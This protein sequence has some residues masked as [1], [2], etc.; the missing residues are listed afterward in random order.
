MQNPLSTVQLI[1]DKLI[2]DT[3]FQYRLEIAPVNHAFANETIGGMQF[4][5][6][7]R[8]F[9]LGRPALAYALTQLV[10]PCAAKMTVQVEHNDGCKIWLN[11]RPVYEQKGDRKI[12]LVLNE[13]SL[14]MS[15]ECELNLC[16]GRIP[17]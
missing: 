9:G 7:G 5:D 14:E 17:C 1:G 12:K 2:R 8:T 4:V 6:F 10:A 13:R 3:S 11:G 15:N 16:R